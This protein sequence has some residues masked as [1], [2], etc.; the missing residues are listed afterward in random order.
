MTTP[1]TA[2]ATA[3]SRAVKPVALLFPEVVPVAVD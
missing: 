1:T 3:P 2:A